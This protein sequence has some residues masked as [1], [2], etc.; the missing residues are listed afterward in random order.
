[1]RDFTRLWGPLLAANVGDDESAVAEPE[2]RAVVLA[3]LK[4]LLESKRGA[5]PGDGLPHIRIDKDGND[6]S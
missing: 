5:D 4:A 2:L 6:D 1:V 3:D